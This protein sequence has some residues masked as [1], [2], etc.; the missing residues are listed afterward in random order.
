MKIR[1][2]TGA[3]LAALLAA[4][5][6]L[7]VPTALAAGAMHRVSFGS[8]TVAQSV[9]KGATKTVQTDLA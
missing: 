9:S 3:T 2:L 4:A 6:P 7:A 5:T 1:R 8:G